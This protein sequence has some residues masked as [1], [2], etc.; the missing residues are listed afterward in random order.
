MSTCIKEY[1]H[2]LF[3]MLLPHQQPIGFYMTFPFSYTFTYQ[4][5][6]AI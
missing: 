4:L 1:Q 6:W 5:V 3:I 2:Q